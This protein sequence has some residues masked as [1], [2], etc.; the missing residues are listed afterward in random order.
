VEL[1][2]TVTQ[3]PEPTVVLSNWDTFED[4]RNSRYKKAESENSVGFL[5]FVAETRRRIKNG[6]RRKN[7]KN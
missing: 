2:V 5:T 3:N 6:M 1:T 4:Q 7:V